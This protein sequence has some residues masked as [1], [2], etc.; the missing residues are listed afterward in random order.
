MPSL[1]SLPQGLGVGMS[2]FV[3]PNLATGCGLLKGIAFPALSHRWRV[4]EA[5]DGGWSEEAAL[6]GC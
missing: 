4:L 6:Y 1:G 3:P 5:D 2:V